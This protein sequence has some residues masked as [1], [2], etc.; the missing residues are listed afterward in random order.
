MGYVF[1]KASA[2]VLPLKTEIWPC[3][4]LISVPHDFRFFFLPSKSQ[5]AIHFG[6]GYLAFSDCGGSTFWLWKASGG[7]LLLPPAFGN[8]ICRLSSS[9]CGLP[10][11]C[12]NAI[13]SSRYSSLFGFSPSFGLH[14]HTEL[15]PAF[16]LTAA[17]YV[18]PELAAYS[19]RDNSRRQKTSPFKKIGVLLVIKKIF[20]PVYWCLTVFLC[21]TSF[22]QLLFLSILPNRLVLG[23]AGWVGCLVFHLLLIRMDHFLL[24]WAL[25]VHV[26]SHSVKPFWIDFQMR[27]WLLQSKTKSFYRNIYKAKNGF[28]LE[29]KGNVNKLYSN[30]IIR[31]NWTKICCKAFVFCT[32]HSSILNELSA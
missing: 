4:N 29:C 25:N 27:K 12:R 10:G 13:V 19:S 24:E 7:S 6:P 26:D 14:W 1:K 11:Q 30:C 8:L 21:T 16:S 18:W 23:V 17:E 20:L 28:P 3:L 9:L 32:W 31:I 15:L 5:L 2:T 22:P